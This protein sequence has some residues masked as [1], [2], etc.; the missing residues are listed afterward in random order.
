MI[1]QLM[2]KPQP[3]QEASAEVSLADRIKATCDLAAQYIE[4][5][6]LELKATPDGRPISID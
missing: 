2:K 1:K 5:R 4:S 3:K 6:A